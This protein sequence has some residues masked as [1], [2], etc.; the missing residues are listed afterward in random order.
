MLFFSL[1]EIIRSASNLD[2]IFES[3]TLTENPVIEPADDKSLEVSECSQET[4][5][6]END[7]IK[8]KE[9]GSLNILSLIN[10]APKLYPAP[11][12]TNYENLD[13]DYMVRSLFDCLLKLECFIDEISNLLHA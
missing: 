8:V 7:A 11:Y 10:S 6:K 12:F 4:L 5:G 1:L 2:P 3:L 9:D 13:S